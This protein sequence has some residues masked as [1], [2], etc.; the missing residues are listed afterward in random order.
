MATG[1]QLDEQLG[2]FR[3]RFHQ[4]DLD[5]ASARCLC[6]FLELQSNGYENAT[7]RL[8]CEQM[9][10]KRTLLLCCLTIYLCCH[11]VHVMYDAIQLCCCNQLAASSRASREQCRPGRLNASLA[12]RPIVRFLL[13]R[14]TGAGDENRLIYAPLWW[15]AMQLQLTCVRTATHGF[16]HLGSDGLIL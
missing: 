1:I 7:A 13:S 15:H 11:I 8:C 10:L 5:R 3:R 16:C 12:K 6:V 14:K 9:W 4:Q 2:P